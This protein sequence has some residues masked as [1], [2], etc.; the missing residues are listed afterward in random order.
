MSDDKSNKDDKGGAQ[1]A[2]VSLED[3]FFKLGLEKRIR[4]TFRVPIDESDNVKVII[5]NIDYEVM[6]LASMGIGIKITK[7]DKFQVGDVIN[8]LRVIINDRTFRLEGEIVHITPDSPDT[9]LCGIKFH[10]MTAE[11]REM[12]LDYLHKYG[13]FDM[14]SV[15]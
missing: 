13:S 1:K 5:D 14:D 15:Y 7:L 9:S 8:P 4:Q 10:N 11:I 3:S 6:D 12:L 2:T